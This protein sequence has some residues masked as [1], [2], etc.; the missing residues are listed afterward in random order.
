MKTDHPKVQK[1]VAKK[2]VK[3]ELEQSLTQK[4]FALLDDRFS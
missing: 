2:A 3:K 1:K 4:F